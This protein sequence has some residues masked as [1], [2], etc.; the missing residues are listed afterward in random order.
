MR[1]PTLFVRQHSCRDSADLFAP[2]FGQ[3][4]E[5]W[6]S[7][8]LRESTSEDAFRGQVCTSVE[9]YLSFNKG[10]AETTKT[11]ITG[12]LFLDYVKDFGSPH[13]TIF[14]TFFW[15]TT[16]EVLSFFHSCEKRDNLPLTLRARAMGS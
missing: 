12:G 1:L 2:L 5:R 8:E 4:G 16:K 10:A 11:A 9:Y 13:W 3:D 14:P 6:F 15:T 7:V